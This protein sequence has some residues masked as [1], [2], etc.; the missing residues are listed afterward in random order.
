MV[1][2]CLNAI[3]GCSASVIVYLNHLRLDSSLV[4][5]A[6]TMLEPFPQSIVDLFAGT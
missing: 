3:I 4:Y 5:P 2:K 6:F 1:V